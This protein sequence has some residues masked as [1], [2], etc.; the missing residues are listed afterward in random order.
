MRPITLIICAMAVFLVTSCTKDPYDDVISNARSI[1]AVTLGNG[2]TQVGPAV[3]VPDSNKVYVQVLMNGSADLSKVA[4]V[5]QTSYKASVSPGSGQIV[6]FASANN[7]YEYTVTSEAGSTRKWTIQLV[8]FTESLP[9]TYKITSLSVYGGTGPEYG[10]G[11]VL[12]LT[13]KPWVWPAADGPSAEEDNI[14]TFTFTGVTP[15][16]NTYG[17]LQNAAG[18][19]GKYADF[20][21]VLNPATDVNSFYRKI[22]KGTSTWE[23]NYTTKTVTFTAADGTKTT[24]SFLSAGTSFDFGNGNK[25]TIADNAFD[26]TLNGVDDWGNIYS[27]YDKFVK[28]PRRYWIEVKKQ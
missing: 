6:N 26:F 16:G 8:P 15:S 4:P 20:K 17:T 21:F 14:L 11:A 3:I 24:G 25:K 23:R 19:D 9:G 27:D 13:D 1:E 18:P 22:P 12:K 7:Q 5:I 10:G 2:L 28:R